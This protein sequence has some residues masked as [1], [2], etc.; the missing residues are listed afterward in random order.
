MSGRVDWARVTAEAVKI[1]DCGFCS[2][3]ADD[4]APQPFWVGEAYQLGGLVLVARNP[5]SNKELPAAA[6]Q[7]LRE[8]HRDRSQ[9]AFATWSR[10][11]IAHMIGGPW[12]QWRR[13]FEPAVHGFAVPEQLA[14]LNVVPFC[15]NDNAVPTKAMLAHGRAEHLAPMLALLRPDAVITRYQDAGLAVAQ[16]PGPWQHAEAL[17]LDGRVATKVAVVRVRSAL[18]ARGIRAASASDQSDTPN[19]S[20]APSTAPS[21]EVSGS[22]EGGLEGVRSG[23]LAAL[24]ATSGY[25]PA[26]RAGY[27]SV[28]DRPIWA[29]VDRRVSSVLVKF[30]V[31]PPYR[32]ASAVAARLGDA[33][34]AAEVKDVRSRSGSTRLWVFLERPADLASL[35][36][37]F[38][39]LWL[40]YQRL[41]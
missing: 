31:A 23:L 29:F 40:D 2:Q 39:Q 1:L 4:A 14:W 24:T 9:A 33:G 13:A 35:Q 36:A 8:L 20:P 41:K 27:T 12:T 37:E 16:I 17:C 26:G 28:G 38:H 18:A 21:P 15:T 7:L 3:H 10:W 34:M 6:K 32:V 22:G 5:A 30:R 11:R 25:P 19:I